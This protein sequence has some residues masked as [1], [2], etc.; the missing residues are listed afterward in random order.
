MLTNSKLILEIIN[1]IIFGHRRALWWL[2]PGEGELLIRPV[3]PS[4]PFREWNIFQEKFIPLK[5]APYYVSYVNSLNKL[6]V[7][8]RKQP[9]IWGFN[10]DNLGVEWESL[11]SGVARQMAVNWFSPRVKE[12]NINVAFMPRAQRIEHERAFYNV[13]NRCCGHQKIFYGKQCYE[14]FQD[15]L[16]EVNRRWNCQPILL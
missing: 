11:D 13:M 14:A 8:G 1:D 6:Y 4:Q 16:V 7:S 2:Y 12:E 15:T 3:R 5:P 10:P 9:N